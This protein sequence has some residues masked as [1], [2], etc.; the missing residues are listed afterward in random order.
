MAN[1]LQ[2]AGMRGDTSANKALGLLGAENAALVSAVDSLV[3]YALLRQGRL[4][5]GR[6]C[7]RLLVRG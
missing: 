6:G 2:L 3:S 7:V 1:M 4:R 5:Q